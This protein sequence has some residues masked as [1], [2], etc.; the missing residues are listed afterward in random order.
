MFDPVLEYI[1]RGKKKFVNVSDKMMEIDVQ[2]FMVYFI[3]RLPNPSFSPSCRPRPASS[4]SDVQLEP[5]RSNCS[6][7]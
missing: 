2:K 5:L 4:I 6:A 7:S 1:S 3:G